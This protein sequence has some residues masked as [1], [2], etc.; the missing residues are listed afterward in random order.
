MKLMIFTLIVNRT[1]G[2]FG[3]FKYFGYTFMFWIDNYSFY[4]P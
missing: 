1:S 4:E 3:A 2:A